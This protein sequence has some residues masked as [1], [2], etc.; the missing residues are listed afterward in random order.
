MISPRSRPSYPNWI[1]IALSFYAF[2]SIGIAEGGLGVLL[3]SILETY[4]LSLATVTVLFIS[5][6]TGYAIAA[7]ISSLLSSVLGLARSLLLA[8][9]LLTS[10]LSI[11]AFTTHWWVMVAAGLLLGLGAGLIDAGIN[12]FI[13]SD[14]KNAA[15]MGY[16]HAFYGIGALS[17]PII[18]TTLLAWEV[19]WRHIYFLVAGIVSL[20]II[21]MFWAVFHHYSPMMLKPVTNSNPKADLRQALNTPIV[22]VSALLLLIYVGTEVAIGNWAYTVQHVSRGI[23]AEVAG[24]SIA[25]YWLGLTLGRLAM[26]QLIKHWGA[27]RTIDV[28]LALLLIGL[29]TWGW[30]PHQWLSLP[31]MG[32]ALATI[33]PAMIWLTPQRVAAP[34]VPAAIGFLASMGSL[35]SASIPTIV[36]WAADRAGLEIIPMLLVPL[37]IVMI[38]LHRWLVRHAPSAQVLRSGRF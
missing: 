24:Y 19:Y 14:Q 38:G 23:P 28:S 11:Y 17:G 15:L 7:T 8:S 10:A 35:G 22:L 9:I 6:V 2:I 18:A 4:H 26:G 32:I 31:L 37:T 3:P 27:I 12:T 34:I 20:T 1:G 30:L 13:A 5:Q 36:G 25:G 33:F 21:G 16:L 29:L